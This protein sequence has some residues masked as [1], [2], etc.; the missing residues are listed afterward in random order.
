M[1]AFTRLILAFGAASVAAGWGHVSAQQ[2]SQGRAAAATVAMGGLEVLQVRPNFY[3]I[4][5]AGANISVQIGQDGV[6]V[7]DAGSADHADQVVAEIKKLTK[8]PIRYVIDTSAD[9][10]HIGGNEKLSRAGESIVPT[11]GLNTMARTRNCCA[12]VGGG[13]ADR[14]QN[15]VKGDAVPRP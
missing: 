1:T 13:V 10:D 5:G 7:V 2:K 8:Q 4:A 11:G 12:G 14:D 3:V 9:P 6:V 15:C